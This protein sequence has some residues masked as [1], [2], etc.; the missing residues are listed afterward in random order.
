MDNFKIKLKKRNL[1]LIKNYKIE[2]KIYEKI[3]DP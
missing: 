3:Q 1:S 2:E